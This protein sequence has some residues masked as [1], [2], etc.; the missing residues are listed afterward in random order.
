M[1]LIHN[2]RWSSLL[3]NLKS[4]VPLYW[5][6]YLM[7]R[8]RK[9]E[10]WN[11]HNNFKQQ[12]QSCVWTL[13]NTNKETIHCGL[14]RTC[15]ENVQLQ[16]IPA[17]QSAHSQSC[18]NRTTAASCQR[19]FHLAKPFQKVPHYTDAR[20]DVIGKF[21]MNRSDQRWVTNNFWLS[22]QETIQT[23]SAFELYCI[24][25]IFQ[26]VMCCILWIWYN[27]TV[28]LPNLSTCCRPKYE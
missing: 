11:I 1:T 6:V 14:W 8:S 15:N 28:S 20:G 18:L 27:T 7:C 10:R 17:N 23:I 24:S 25:P 4:E 16:K 19:V 12:Q 9:Y 13:F 3:F 22:A 2:Y 21:L 5:W 26:P